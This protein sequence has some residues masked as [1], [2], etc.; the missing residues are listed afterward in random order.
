MLMCGIRTLL[1]PSMCPQAEGLFQEALR[2]CLPPIS[3]SLYWQAKRLEF[4]AEQPSACAPKHME[5]AVGQ[6]VD[7]PAFMKLYEAASPADKPALWAEKRA[8]MLQYAVA[9][10]SLLLARPQLLE[11]VNPKY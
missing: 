4:P 3:C 2:L 1:Q 9:T 6:A 7:L 8:V 11:Q 10:S 5:A